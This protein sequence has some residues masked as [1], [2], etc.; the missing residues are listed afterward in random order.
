MGPNFVKDIGR[1]GRPLSRVIIIDDIAE[2]FQLQP[3]NG[4]LIKAWMGEPEDTVL[5]ELEPLLLGK[6]DQRAN[7]CRHRGEEGGRCTV[8]AKDV[9]DADERSDG[10]R[11]RAGP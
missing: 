2:N 5:R 10:E 6:P 8:G 4:I 7:A 9:Q 3:E 11:D 1:L